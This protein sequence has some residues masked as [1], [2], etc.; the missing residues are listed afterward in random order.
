[1]PLIAVPL[2]A[3]QVAQAIF[4]YFNSINIAAATQHTGM[5]V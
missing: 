1:M 2:S 5:I 3:E 4:G